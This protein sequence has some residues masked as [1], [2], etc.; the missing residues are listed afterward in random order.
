MDLNTIREK[1]NEAI[2]LIISNK[3]DDNKSFLNNEEYN[4]RMEDVK[5]SKNL[6]KCKKDYRNIRKYDVIIINDKERLIKSITHNN[7]SV[8]YY[9]KNEELFDILYSTHIAIGHGGRDRMMAEIKLKYCNITKE[10]IMGFL[11]FCTD[12]HK[13]SS[14]PRRGLVSKPILHSAYNSRAQI[15]LIDMQSQSINNYRFIM[16]YQEHLTKFVTLKPLKTKRAE[17]IAYNLIDIYTTFGAP[18]ILHSDNGRE[19]VN[20]IINELHTMWEDV[21]IVHGKSRQSQSKGSVERANQDVE[22]MLAT[23]MA[24]NKSTDW[25]SGFKFIQ[26]RKNRAFHSGTINSY[27]LLNNCNFN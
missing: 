14:N 23:W 10:T 8:Q 9:D 20:N 22:D 3:R 4:R 6:K 1:F 11:S 19:F 7:D 13:K 21:K 18:A 2:S 16:N 26:F 17:E 15:D 12:C 5:R 27:L 25:P 24:E